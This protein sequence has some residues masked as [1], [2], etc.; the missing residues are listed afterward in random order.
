V[1]ASLF[2]Q[3]PSAPNRAGDEN[4]DAASDSSHQGISRQAPLPLP[5]PLAREPAKQACECGLRR[6][7]SHGQPQTKLSPIWTS[8]ALPSHPSNTA[9]CQKL[10]DAIHQ[11]APMPH[12]FRRLKTH[13][14]QKARTQST[15]PPAARAIR[16]N[17]PSTPCA[18]PDDSDAT[19]RAK[20]E[21]RNP[22]EELPC[23]RA[24]Q[25]CRHRPESQ[26]IAKQE[27]CAH[28]ATKI[29]N[30]PD[31]STTGISSQSQ[32]SNVPR[33]KHESPRRI[34]ARPAQNSEN[35]F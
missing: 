11:T 28:A 35:S 5:W 29:D 6:V 12:P 2:P 7:V 23:D 21:T 15:H 22:H 27:G 4:A 9:V 32:P 14:L 30:R 19:H 20:S 8:Q 3:I 33:Q 13:D 25:S 18:P 17:P 1:P 34:P 31:D 10:C 24:I 16:T 26:P